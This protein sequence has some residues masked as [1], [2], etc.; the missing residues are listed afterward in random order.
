MPFSNRNRNRHILIKEDFTNLTLF[1]LITEHWLSVED[2]DDDEDVIYYFWLRKIIKWIID[3]LGKKWPER[4]PSLAYV[5][6][7][8]DQLHS[9]YDP[10]ACSENEKYFGNMV[11]Y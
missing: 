2:Y 8:F 6:L 10:K 3:F 4:L 9:Q 1:Q 11:K 5:L 7:R